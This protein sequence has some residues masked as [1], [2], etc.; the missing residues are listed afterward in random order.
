[1]LK[2]LYWPTWEWALDY[3]YLLG[4]ASIGAGYAT[5]S[6][7]KHRQQQWRRRR[8][9]QYRKKLS[10][11]KPKFNPITQSRLRSPFTLPQSQ[12]RTVTSHTIHDQ[13]RDIQLVRA[14]KKRG[15][16]MWVK[17]DDCEPI[18]KFPSSSNHSSRKSKKHGTNK[19]PC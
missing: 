2:N 11:L 3:P 12:Q 1:M 8:H 5:A 14:K 6:I 7:Q 13:D 16:T 15:T 9:E 10:W 4:G 17:C 18:Y 19:L